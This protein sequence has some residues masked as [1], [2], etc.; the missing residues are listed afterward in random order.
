MSSFN[1]TTFNVN[2][3]DNIVKTFYEGMN[4]SV[5]QEAQTILTEFQNNPD[6]WLVA[7]QILEQSNNIQAKQFLALG[8][9]EEFIKVKWNLLPI[10]QRLTM[11]NYVVKY[12]ID[13]ITSTTSKPHQAAFL[14]KLDLV[15]VQ[16]LKKDW[17]QY[18]PTFIQ[19]IVNS[20][21]INT[22]LCENN[23]KILRFLS[24]EVF[25]YSIDFMTIAKKT[26]LKNQMANEFDSVFDLCKRILSSPN[27]R[28]SLILATLETLLKLL[29]WIP[30]QFL[31]QQQQDLLEILNSNIRGNSSIQRNLSFQCLIEIINNLNSITNTSP[32]NDM[33][34]SIY[35][36]FYREMI[37]IM[38]VNSV[39]TIIQTFEESNQE[40]QDF[41][42]TVVTFFTTIFSKHRKLIEANDN[43][44][45]SIQ[46][47][48]FNYL[49]KISR[50]PDREIWR[51]CLEYWSE[52]ANDI[53]QEQQTSS[54]YY[55]ILK[56]LGLV[57]IDN[58]VKPDKVLVIENIDGEITR[59]FIKQS[60]T[61]S[62]SKTTH[63][64]FKLLTRIDPIFIHSLLHE[65]LNQ[66][67][68]T[69]ISWSWDSLFRIC[70]AI[71]ASLGATDK[72]SENRFLE[73]ILI[74]NLLPL[75]QQQQQEGNHNNNDLDQEWVVASCVLYIVGQCPYFMKSHWDFTFFIIQKIFIYLRQPTQS[76]IK[77]MA[78]DAFLKIAEGC[79]EELSIPHQLTTTTMMPSVLE[80]VLSDLK[81]LTIQLESQQLCILYEA[82]STLISTSTL[83][84]QMKQH[85]F[86]L[87][88][89]MP[90]ETLKK[91][92]I[93]SIR[94]IINML[95]V[96]IA[97][98][99]RI[100]SVLFQ[101][102]IQTIAPTLFH[103]YELSSQ[104]I[105]LVNNNSDTNS[106]H[107]MIR[108]L[109]LNLFETYFLST[110][111][112]L[113]CLEEEDK[114]LISNL[115]QVVFA[116]YIN[117][118]TVPEKR[119]AQLLSLLTSLVEKLENLPIVWPD[120]LKE[121]ID[122]EYITTLPMITSNFVDFPEIR[123]E[124]YRL[125]YAL[126]T[127]Y[128]IVLELFQMS[129]ELFQLNIDSILWGTKH[130]TKEIS[131]IALQ[132]CLH[133]I[134]YASQMEDEDI[135]SQFFELYYVK[136]LTSILE[137]LVDPDCRN[138]FNFQSEILSRMLELVQE[139]EIYTRVFDPN[140]V[141][142]PLMSN[143]E[144]LQQ[145]VLNLLCSA[146][147]LLQKNQ[148][149]VLVKGMFEYSGDL[150]RFQDDIRD[151]L[152]DIKEVGEAREGEQRAEDELNAELDLLRNL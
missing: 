19:E 102:Q 39:D 96:N 145:Y 15:L 91:T 57:M 55:D 43:S 94:I 124:F 10:E 98:C 67:L 123:H 1:P 53:L 136:I 80:M 122:I 30:I 66:L 118:T 32:Y 128:F 47:V 8:I 113:K 139:G 40:T 85:S 146:F 105:N 59:E 89:E 13:F 143:V 115:I 14:N 76:G 34:L 60:D 152:I 79:G 73:A 87:L 72:C 4:N 62:L 110:D 144:F 137:I 17:P 63:H 121:M 3:F 31:Y 138:A 68:V 49:L 112:K 135:S 46:V 71:G 97:T 107:I 108:Q 36:M 75:L 114:K 7:D 9:L 33:I 134:N 69:N 100:G 23:M 88:M 142:D 26:K 41:I 12:M 21:S 16:I 37:N 82:I 28:I 56:Q 86:N 116:D 35:N 58:M 54:Y 42:K 81:V 131:E 125:L 20:S 151:F 2:E 130:T 50:I 150:Q 109:V 29:S 92:S 90:N 44:N 99:K 78:C 18:W 148:I 106:Q 77:E 61:T 101:N 104:A 103:Y 83:S 93:S 132:T 126:N 147:P 111:N 140:Q 117:A 64:V 70:W 27:Q 127:K 5:R 149:E 74:N 45:N 24:E 22:N 120:F 6:S 65:Q 119:E 133:I 11:R 141:S 52:L 51:I 38:P 129:P 84:F 25:D 48:L 95:R